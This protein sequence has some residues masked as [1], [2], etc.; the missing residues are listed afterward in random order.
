M[1]V[2]K[3]SRFQVESV[4]RYFLAVVSRDVSW[5]RSDSAPLF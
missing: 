4:M 3:L 5:P 2:A 1:S